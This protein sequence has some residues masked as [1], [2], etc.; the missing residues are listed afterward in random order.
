MG[1]GTCKFCGQTREIVEVE[2]MTQEEL[3]ASAAYACDCPGGR[4]TAKRMDQIAAARYRIEQLFGEEAEDFGFD[5]KPD[6]V[7]TLQ[8]LASLLIEKG[9]DEIAVRFG[10]TIKCKIVR[11]QSGA[12]RVER[13]ESKKYRLEE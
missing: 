6:A 7:E 9:I 5:P 2:K 4:A 12:I 10:G 3:D 13:S 8:M 11:L 1:L